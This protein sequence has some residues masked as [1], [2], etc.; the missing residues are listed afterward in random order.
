MTDT[1]SQRTTCVLPLNSPLADLASAGG[2]GAN[3]SRLARAGFPVPNGFLVTTCAYRA[4]VS[5]NRLEESILACL[6]AG[7]AA[8]EPD[9]SAL[10]AAS[11]NIRRLFNSG[12]MPEDLAAELLEAYTRLDG[13]AVG[14]PAVAV[15]SSATAEDLPG[16]SFAGQQDTFLNVVGKRALLQAVVDCWSS[17]WTARAIGYRTRNHVPHQGAALAVVVQKMVQSQ[18]SGVLFTANPVSGLRSETVIDAAFGLGEALVSGK[19]EP[20]H[21]VVDAAR[22]KELILAKTLGAKALSIHA[23]AGGGT[24]TRLAQGVELARR[25][26]LPDDQILALACLGQQVA[27]M[28]DF[29]QDIEWA[30]AEDQLYILQSRPIT[31]LYPTPLG[32]PPEPLKVM[33]SFAAIQGMHDPLTPLGLDALKN[34]FAFGASLFGIQ[35][36][37]ETQVAVFPAGERLW[38]NFTNLL[39]NSTGRAIVGKVIGMVE[40]TIGQALEEI[41][42]DPRLL[43]GKPGISLHAKM[44]IARFFVPAASNILL[45]LLSPRRRREYILR[46]G[47]QVLEEIRARAAAIRG[48]RYERLAAQAGLLDAIAADHLSRTLICFISGVA[49]GVASWNLF[50]SLVAGLP[51]DGAGG[52][53]NRHDL[54]LEITRGMPHNPTSEMDLILWKMARTIRQDAPSIQAMA[55]LSAAELAERYKGQHLPALLTRTV[56]QFLEKYGGRGLAEIDM[57]RPRWGEDATY[58]FAT[59]G[60]Y[61]QIED[62]DQAPDAVFARGAESAQRAIDQLALALRRTRQGWI[63]ARLARFLAGRARQLMGLRES[64]KFF[65]VRMMWIIR[66]ELLKTGEEFVRSGELERADDLCFLSLDEIAA[67]AHRQ[68]RDWAAFIAGRRETYRAELMRRQVPR[69]L[70]SDGRAFYEGLIRP[71]GQAAEGGGL[72]GSPVSPGSS[73]GKVRVVLDPR[74]AHLE[75]GEIL[76]CPG[77]DPSWT[78][79]FLSAAGLVMET[80]GMM[81]HGAVVAREYG[82]PAI[83]GVDRATHRL[84]TGQRIRMDGSTGEIFL[85]EG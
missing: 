18:V 62:G 49:S 65:A 29:P 42:D 53:A 17:L 67:F 66:S 51:E 77:T 43:P 27:E 84:H 20:D 1:I 61:L 14:E 8:S 11:E 24:I 19:V 52:L 37:S 59:L 9:P 75:P 35:A 45:N 31:S 22:G 80:G 63:K 56:G 39:R 41:K 21:Y 34:I 36:T 85:L 38:V 68:P 60:S 25:Q 47:E 3:L 16:M 54:V 79:L 50:N 5:S 83:V 6:P 26:A 55:S 44:Q 13:P 15:R 46:N 64:P 70:L 32:M 48:D 33:V 28:Y 58:V 4:F 23:R 12:K 82:I 81:T 71:G 57:G 78:P 72:H 69:L 30:A 10:E 73:E 74:Q 40:P 76:V 7:T 2:K